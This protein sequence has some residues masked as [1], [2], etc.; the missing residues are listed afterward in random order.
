MLKVGKNLLGHR[1]YEELEQAILSFPNKFRIVY[2]VMHEEDAGTGKGPKK[3]WGNATKFIKAKEE[4][5][6]RV[7]II[8]IKLKERL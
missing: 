1:N 8:S 7:R 3:Y 5:G 6:W 4:H 2:T